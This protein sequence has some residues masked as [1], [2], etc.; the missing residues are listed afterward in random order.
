MSKNLFPLFPLNVVLFPDGLLPLRIFEP[1]YLDMVTNCVKTGTA[2]GVVSVAENS[3]SAEAESE[4]AFSPV[5]TMA[6]IVNFDVPQTG[7]MFINCIG[8][9]RFRVDSA[10]QQQDGLWMGQI[11]PI[12]DDVIL[13]LPPDLQFTSESLRKLIMVLE[14]Q[15][16]SEAEMPLLKPYR[17]DDCGWVANRWCELLNIPLKQKQTLLE[18]DSPLIRLELVNDMISMG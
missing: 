14:K 2:F 11:D 3:E 10:S 5:G 9:S 13:A 7:L 17:F 18:L 6:R 4:L 1:R 12:A 16:I 15:G 8:Q